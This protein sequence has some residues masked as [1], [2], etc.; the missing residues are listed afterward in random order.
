M[1]TKKLILNN[2]LLISFVLI[3]MADAGLVAHFKFDGNV[4]DTSGNGYLAG[5]GQLVGDT[6]YVAGKSGHALDFDGDGDFIRAMVA[7]NG[8]GG[9]IPQ[10][11]PNSSAI[12]ISMWIKMDTYPT[13][14]TDF[15]A[16]SSWLPGDHSIEFHQYGFGYQT[17]FFIVAQ[18]IYLTEYPHQT[19]TADK[20]SN[21]FHLAITYDAVAGKAYMYI[22]GVAGAVA[23]ITSGSFVN[24]GNYTIGGSTALNDRYFDGQIDEVRIYDYALNSAEVQ[25]IFHEFDDVSDQ[26]GSLGYLPSDFNFDCCVNLKDMAILAGDWLKCTQPEDFK[27]RVP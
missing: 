12:S 16:P 4:L 5:D 17:P 26:C 14:D 20:L 25:V 11:I 1:P 21:W 13:A 24:I 3:S 2:V 27:C 9:W 22:D 18:G 7:P 15:I 6:H 10:V 8:Y 23:P 19:I